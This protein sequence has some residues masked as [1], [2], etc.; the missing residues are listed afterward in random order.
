MRGS[1]GYMSGAMRTIIDL[2]QPIADRGGDRDHPC[3]IPLGHDFAKV[4]WS[5]GSVGVCGCGSV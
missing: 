5:L 3:D 1:C 2:E 4:Q